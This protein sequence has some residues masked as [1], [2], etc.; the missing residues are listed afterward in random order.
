MM[1]CSEIHCTFCTALFQ[2][3]FARGFVKSIF[4]KFMLGQTNWG[5]EQACVFHVQEEGC[6]VVSGNNDN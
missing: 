4:L 2:V 1:R 6:V 3:M 5:K